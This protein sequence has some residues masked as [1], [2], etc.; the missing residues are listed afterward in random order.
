[1]KKALFICF[2]A[3]IFVVCMIST[4]LACMTPKTGGE[5]FFGE[6]YIWSYLGVLLPVIVLECAKLLCF[7]TEYQNGKLF[8]FDIIGIVFAAL[9]YFIW[10]VVLIPFRPFASMISNFF[11]AFLPWTIALIGQCLLLWFK[12]SKSNA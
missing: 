1:M 8:A 12:S 2:D 5:S 9:G 11:I 4:F 7:K 6:I 10:Y 3:I